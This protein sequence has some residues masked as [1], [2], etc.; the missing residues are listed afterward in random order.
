MLEFCYNPYAVP[1]L[2]TAFV[3]LIIAMIALQKAHLERVKITFTLF[4]LSMIVWL[5]CFSGMYSSTNPETAL[6]WARLGFAG[7]TFIPILAYHFI[8]SFLGHKRGILLNLLYASTIPTLVLAQTKYVYKNIG[9]FF[10]GYYPLAGSLYF[11]FMAIFFLV[12]SWGLILLYSALRESK[13]KDQ[14]LRT[15]QIKYVFYAFSFGTTGVA[16]YVIKYNISIYPYGY[17]SALTFISVIAYAIVK[18]RL[19]DINLVFR[20]SLVFLSSF[21]VIFMGVLPILM[22]VKENTSALVIVFG[23][24]VAL[25]PTLRDIIQSKTA[26]AID[27]IVFK[28][29]Y[30]YMT[31]LRDFTET[32][33]FIPEEK[34]LIETL[35]GK[36]AELMEAKD[37]SIHLKNKRENHPSPKITEIENYLKANG[38]IYI[39]EE[40][41]ETEHD[42]RINIAIPIAFRE[43]MLGVITL[44]AKTTGE[45]YTHLDL[46]LLKRL[47]TQLAVVLSYKKMEAELRENEATKHLVAM[48]LALSHQFHSHLGRIQTHFAIVLQRTP[49]S[50]KEALEELTK[51][52]LEDMSAIFHKLTELSFY[53]KLSQPRPRETE[54]EKIIEGALVLQRERLKEKNVMLQ[55]SQATNL[56]KILVDPDLIT[57]AVSNILENAIWAVPEKRGKIEIEIKPEL[58]PTA[59][60][61]QK[62]QEWIQ[63]EI[64]DNGK[65]MSEE[66]IQKAYDAFYT[67]RNAGGE[68]QKSGCGLG[69]TITKRILDA[70]GSNIVI[71]SKPGETEITLDIPVKYEHHTKAQIERSQMKKGA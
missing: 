18:Y 45:M 12:F 43:D 50:E 11:I 56:P 46:E 57:S 20:K 65:G 60:M 21:I 49:E 25:A 32:M 28:N 24:S 51:L 29:K 38:E 22:M 16:D 1:P 6:R 64:K 41:S 3:L 23:I 62:S 31:K 59:E 5:I 48:S 52:T 30:E 61:L 14:P 67:T 42:A 69:L 4:C 68:G 70:H 10:W 37:A 7:I 36:L 33:V 47:G 2:I 19:M 13:R 27:K 55:R 8:L 66:S 17:L 9:T 53:A 35:T 44:G 63:I 54:I 39:Q 71:K 58:T 26:G 15:Q 34:E 40:H